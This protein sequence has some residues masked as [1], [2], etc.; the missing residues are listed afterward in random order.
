MKKKHER[1]F[2]LKNTYA[3]GLSTRCLAC[4]AEYREKNREKNR[5]AWRR[6]REKNRDK[7]NARHK[8]YHVENG[9]RRRADFA[10]N[11]QKNRETRLESARDYYQQ[12]KER[13]KQRKR[14]HSL[15]FGDAR[16]AADLERYHKNKTLPSNIVKK[17]IYCERYLHYIKVP[18]QEFLGGSSEL[19]QQH[20]ESMMQPGMTWSNYGRTWRIRRIVGM[21]EALTKE[22]QI[23]IGVYLNL[24]PY[25]RGEGG[26]VCP[27]L[28]KKVRFNLLGR[29]KQTFGDLPTRPKARK[30][31]AADYLPQ[32]PQQPQ[33]SRRGV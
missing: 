2:G 31:K 22:E 27:D 24:M 14:K 33:Q 6:W 26:D 28:Q 15:V 12:N 13:V 5:E 10:Q 16:R 11:Y 21:N 18:M 25:W 30:T 9:D 19:A 7:E 23:K 4:D 8:R 32:Q 20:L 1:E 3:D 17:W 29:K